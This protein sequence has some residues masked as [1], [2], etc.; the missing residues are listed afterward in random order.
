[1][2]NA[3]LAQ[4]DYK[5]FAAE[6]DKADGVSD[7]RFL[8]RVALLKAQQ[9]KLTDAAKAR[10]EIR[11]YAD[12]PQP[13]PLVGILDAELRLASGLARDAYAGVEKVEGLRASRLRGRALFDM[14]KASDAR[15]EL[16]DA[17]KIA[18]K[19]LELQAWAEAAHFLAAEGDERKKA[20][21]ALDS[22]GRNAKSNAVRVPHGIALAAVGRAP[23]AREKLERSLKDVSDEY[24]NALA[25]RAHV[26]IAELDLAEGKAPSAIEHVKKALEVNP[27]Y[28]P[29]H[30]LMGRLLI[31]TAPDQALP[32]LTEVVNAEVASVGAE[33]AF[34]RAVMPSDK[35][36]IKKAAADA[37]RRAKQKG[38]TA[39]QLA[40]VVPLVDPAMAAELGVPADGGKKKHGG[41]HH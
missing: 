31:D 35:P 11:W 14:G 39:E 6:L 5:S 22:L 34:V 29:A 10:A 13:D 16:N 40:L 30:D 20:D 25:Y 12:K 23:A 28:L 3:L 1:M 8:V 26:A 41:R 27:G 17:L 33:L 9:G 4:E 18:P 36:E 32:H 21:E 37:L 2:A 7:P 24:P 19:D 38:A 15:E